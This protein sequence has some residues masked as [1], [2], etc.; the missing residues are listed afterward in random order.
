VRGR[1]SDAGP[2]DGAHSTRA[3]LSREVLVSFPLDH[4]PG[5]T[6]WVS[7]RE[8]SASKNHGQIVECG[9]RD[10]AG[11]RSLVQLAH[12]LFSERDLTPV[13]VE[14]NRSRRLIGVGSR[15]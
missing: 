13:P 9:K 6:A 5:A 11:S 15:P 10:R 14:V 12:D 2:S 4:S 1:P 8:L 7:V 3:F